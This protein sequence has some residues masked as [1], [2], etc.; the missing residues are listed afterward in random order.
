MKGDRKNAYWTE[1]CGGPGCGAVLT[2]E[3]YRR[4]GATC[5]LPIQ[6]R[7]PHFTRIRGVKSAQ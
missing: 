5:C 2:V 7:R 6:D 3:I 4:F 1:D